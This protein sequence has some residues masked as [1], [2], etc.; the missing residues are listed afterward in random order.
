MF[1]FLPYENPL[2]LPGEPISDNIDDLLKTYQTR[3]I[4]DIYQLSVLCL[5]LVLCISVAIFVFRKIGLKNYILW[6]I[7]ASI[8]S[9]ISILIF[10]TC[11][12]LGIL[13]SERKCLLAQDSDCLPWTI[14][15]I[16]V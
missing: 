6:L 12:N 8:I 1:S 7:I 16:V 3:I 15:L 5:F 14:S 10:F 9:V 4:Y 13:I 2:A 11:I